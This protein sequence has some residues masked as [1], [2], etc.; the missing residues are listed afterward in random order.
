MSP[1]TACLRA[2]IV[3]LVT[4]VWLFS[5]V[6]SNVSSTRLNE[7]IYNHTDCICVTFLCCAFSYVSSICLPEKRHNHTG[8]ICLVFLQCVF[9]NVSS[10]PMLRGCIVTSIAFVWLFPICIFKCWL[11]EL[12]SHTGKFTL[13]AFAWLFFTVCFQMRPQRTWIS[14]GKF[15]LVAFVW[16]IST[17][18]FQLCPQIAC[19]RIGIFIFGCIHLAFSSVCF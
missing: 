2:C 14:T 9:S 10:N 12:G 18:R 13:V 1:Q 17:V 4:F 11:K 19:P 5:T 6:F 3:T 15:T 7:K 8:C 16:L